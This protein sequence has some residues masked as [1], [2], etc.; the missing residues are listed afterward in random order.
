MLS[1]CVLVIQ[2]YSSQHISTG[3]FLY[4]TP[5]ILSALAQTAS[6]VFNTENKQDHELLRLCGQFIRFLSEHATPCQPVLVLSGAT[7]S[8]ASRLN[9]RVRLIPKRL[10]FFY[11]ILSLNSILSLNCSC[12]SPNRL[13]A[14]ANRIVLKIILTSPDYAFPCAYMASAFA[15]MLNSKALMSLSVP[16]D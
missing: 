8:A 7:L 15:Y 14:A 12:S 2:V 13:K 3:K 10:L 9:L 16:M 5:M 6:Q 4:L 11:N 1:V